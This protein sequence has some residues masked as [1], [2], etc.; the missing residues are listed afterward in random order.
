MRDQQTIFITSF[1]PLIMRNILATP[2]LD[3]LL[4]KNVRVVVF[5]PEKTKFYFEWEFESRGVIVE[6]VSRAL[7]W[8][9]RLFRYL[10]LAALNTRALAI[11]RK[12]ELEGSGTWLAPILG[13]SRV[14]RAFVRALERRLMPRDRFAVFIERYRPSAVFATD[15]QHA[16]DVRLLHEARAR[17]IPAVGMVRSWDNLTSKGFIRVIP[18]ILLVNNEVV[19][20]EAIRLHDIPADQIRVVGIPH[21]DAYLTNRR[22]SREEFF[23]RISGDPAKRLIVFA[24]TGDRYLSNNDVDPGILAALREYAPRDCQILVRLPPHD[25]VASLEKLASDA[26]V[27]IERPAP[28]YAT[29]NP[30]KIEFDFEMDRHLADTLAHASLVISG[31]STI[32][33]DAA[34]FDAPIILAAFDG[35]AVRPYRESVRRYFDYEHHQPILASGGARIARTVAEFRRYLNEYLAHPELDHAGRK[36]IV[37]T[38]CW[39]VDGRSSH[40][41]AEALLGAMGNLG[42]KSE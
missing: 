20:E 28:P 40:R 7:S 38:E 19:R 24:P 14:L 26:R 33:I 35:F 37:A 23:K 1:H 31:P 9:D 13:R 32:A 18:D 17:R 16:N 36:K 4:E 25:S 22:S 15:V 27:I 29:V 6:S 30:R 11:K 41:V 34:F 10:S 3:Y 42:E 12:T 8:Q 5:A 2:I 39:R 21:Y